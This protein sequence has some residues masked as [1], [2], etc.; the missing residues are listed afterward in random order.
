MTTG[1]W[2]LYNASYSATDDGT[3]AT[4]IDFHYY[5]NPTGY[6]KAY[7]S[8]EPVIYVKHNYIGVNGAEVEV[9]STDADSILVVGTAQDRAGGT[10]TATGLITKL[11]AMRDSHQTFTFKCPNHTSGIS[12]KILKVNANEDADRAIDYNLKTRVYSIMLMETN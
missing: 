6:P 11:Q 12:V 3:T 7:E 10:Y 9:I 5:G 4:G 1:I 8:D 2:Q